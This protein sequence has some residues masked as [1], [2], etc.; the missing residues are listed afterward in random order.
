MPDTR[1]LAARQKVLSSLARTVVWFEASSLSSASGFGLSAETCVSDLTI[2]LKSSSLTVS[3]FRGSLSHSAE[4][5]ADSAAARGGR[6]F[7][8]SSHVVGV[9]CGQV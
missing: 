9:E 5:L 4:E 8:G 2:D 3:R 7:F 1:R 6:S